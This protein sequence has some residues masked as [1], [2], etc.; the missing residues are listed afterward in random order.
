M[1]N[2]K[3]SGKLAGHEA[4]STFRQSKDMLASL[5]IVKLTIQFRWQSDNGHP[6]LKL[7][8]N[9]SIY[10]NWLQTCKWS[11]CKLF[12]C[13]YLIQSVH[14]LPPIFFLGTFLDESLKPINVDDSGDNI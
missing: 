14:H 4:Q 5:H 2:F 12:I 1:K 3:L 10:L 6:I 7:L 9:N 8:G 13:K 11:Y